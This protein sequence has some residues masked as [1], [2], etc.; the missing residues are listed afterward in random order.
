MSPEPAASSL[1]EFASALRIEDVPQDVLG[2][3]RKCLVDAVA[4][5]AFGARFPWSRIVADHAMAGAAVGA[6]HLPEI[7]MPALPAAQAALIGGSFAHAFELDSLRKPGA[8][9][10]PGATVALPA[11]AV[12]Q[13]VGADAER[14]LLAIV[15]GSEVMFRIGGATLHSAEARG[16]HAPGIT[17]PFGSAVAAGI[18]TGLSADRMTNAIGIA[19]SLGGGLLAFARGSGGMVKRLHMGRAAQGGVVAADLAARGFEGPSSVLDGDFGVLEAYCP[20]S[21]ASRLTAGLGETWDLR[22]LCLKRYACHVT[23]Q[24]PVEF[25]REAMARHGFTGSDI[26][27]IRLGVSDKVRSHHANPRPTDIAG[28]QYSVPFVLATAALSDPEDPMTFAADPDR[29]DVV[30]LAAKIVLEPGDLGNEKRGAELSIRLTSG[31]VIEGRRT[32][33]RGTPENPFSETD[34]RRKYESLTGRSLA[35]EQVPTGWLS[36]WQ[37]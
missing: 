28:A 22:R 19:G 9:V 1:A 34:L 26:A 30:A 13:E 3:A 8:G 17:G 23:A 32:S 12:A 2:F 15:A 6:C 11:L 33:F 21:D 18:L 5:A 29:A 24:A 35:V 25:L 20:R 7:D 10:H 14:L 37:A 16:F 31:R 27:G 4:C 36:A